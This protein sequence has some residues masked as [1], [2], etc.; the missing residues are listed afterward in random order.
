[1]GKISN[2]L[3]MFN[4]LNT[5]NKYSVKELS[6]KIG[7]S[8]RMIRYYKAELETAG[9]PIE[10]FMGPNG[11][12]FMINSGN[13]YNQLNKYDID[14]LNNVYIELSN[15]NYIYL[16]K[17]NNLI[18][19]IKYMVDIENEKSKY[20]SLKDTENESDIFN[21]LNVAI[22]NKTKLVI[23]YKNLNQ[24]WQQRTIHPLQIFKFQNKYYVTSYCELRN[25][26]RHF[27]FE[28]L[29]IIKT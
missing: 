24:E 23:L 28:R 18:D 2:V 16:D 9:V 17:F 12:Y 6:Q 1:M 8:E 14:L 13:Y 3:V 29:K 10:T 27:D 21:I 20:F 26:I 19:R 25:D 4:Y 22:L 7:V 11:G 15:N 5:G